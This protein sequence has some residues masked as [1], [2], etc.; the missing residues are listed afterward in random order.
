MANN[1]ALNQAWP[2]G[3]I[4]PATITQLTPSLSVKAFVLDH[5]PDSPL[6]QS[7]IYFDALRGTNSGS[8]P[9]PAAP[10]VAPTL[11]Q[12]APAG[13]PAAEPTAV[14]PAAAPPIASGSLQGRLAV[15][16]FN[17]A[18]MDILVYNVADGGILARFPNHRQPDFGKCGGVLLANG[19][20]GGT[21][22]VVRIFP[23]G[24]MRGV[25]ANL[26]DSWPQ[27]SPSC[28]S[29]A[30]ASTKL[31][32]GSWLLYWQD[33]ASD[34]FDAPPM[35]FNKADL[36]GR[37]TVY[38][39]NWRIAYNGCNYWGSGSNCGIYTTDTK[40]GQP[41]RASDQSDDTPTD[42]LGS[43]ILFHSRRSGN[44]DVWA[45]NFDGSG[46]QQL[47]NSPANDGLAT[48][49]PDNQH[50]AFLSNRDGNWAIYVMNI[51]G[52]NQQKLFDVNGGY[53]GGDYD[54]SQERISWGN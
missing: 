34:R 36:R 6:L 7:T 45:V 18:T 8:S 43:R 46:L 1:F 35:K 31:G 49:S 12:S 10:S 28:A 14:Q 11:A 41:N 33:D 29:I 44:W 30:Y 22:D 25:T 23:D 54:W 48:A 32:G 9:S 24:S 5:H 26:E 37:Y 53:G 4:S 38:L 39:D 17:G 40:G 21:N 20:G 51:D 2:A 19:D 27:W 16:V 15:P 42:A 47:T 52:S 3:P 50:I 13:P